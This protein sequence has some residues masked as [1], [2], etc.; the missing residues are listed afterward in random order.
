MLSLQQ[1]ERL[2]GLV[3]GTYDSVFVENTR[4]L[5]RSTA[6]GEDIYKDFMLIA[7]PPFLICHF[8]RNRFEIRAVRCLQHQSEHF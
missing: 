7:S 8:E 4:A 2:K 5:T 3:S 1:R 6:V